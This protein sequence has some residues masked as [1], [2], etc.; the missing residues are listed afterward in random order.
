MAAKIKMLKLLQE[1]RGFANVTNRRPKSRP[2][3]L[4]L[5]Q[6]RPPVIQAALPRRRLNVAM[7]KDD[8]SNLPHPVRINHLKPTSEPAVTVPAP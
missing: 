3:E 8:C 7:G 6:M 2:S 5:A 4:V 1:M